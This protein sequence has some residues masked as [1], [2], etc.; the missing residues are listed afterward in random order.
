MPNWL[1]LIIGYLLGCIPTAYIAGRKKAGKDIRC[2]GDKNP[3]AGNAYRE[4]GPTPGVIVFF[5]DTAKG[6][7]AVLIAQAGQLSQN[8]VMATGLAT[9]IGH[10]WPIFLGFRGGRGVATT[11]GILYVLAPVPMLV[12]TVPT[13]LILLWRR[14]VTPA[15]AFLF[16]IL[17]FVE[18][19]FKTN[20]AIIVY[21][22]FLPALTGVLTFFRTRPKVQR[23]GLVGR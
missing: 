7:A 15:M 6:V 14:N 18:W 9:V 21:G 23:G 13:F 5:V 3:G 8:W 4:L 20:P 11:L 16:I 19:A 2:L 12:M 22:L 10:N 17:P 1:V